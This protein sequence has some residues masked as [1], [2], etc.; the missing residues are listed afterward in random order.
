MVTQSPVEHV[1]VGRVPRPVARLQLA[2]SE[3]VEGVWLRRS[4]GLAFECRA[5]MLC[6]CTVG[7]WFRVRIAV[8]SDAPHAKSA[9]SEWDAWVASESFVHGRSNAIDNHEPN[10][11][12]HITKKSESVTFYAPRLRMTPSRCIALLRSTSRRSTLIYQQGEPSDDKAVVLSSKR[13][14]CF[15]RRHLIYIPVMDMRWN[16]VAG[17]RW[18]TL[19]A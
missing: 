17:L 4:R 12:Y 6:F 5:I 18:V 9:C 15:A 2:T 11:E 13:S 19:A 8:G 3:V 7:R 1:H 14:K 16:L 10:T